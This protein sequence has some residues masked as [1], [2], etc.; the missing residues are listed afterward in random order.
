M[1]DGLGNRCRRKRSGIAR[2]MEPRTDARIPFHGVTR[3]RIQAK[4]ISTFK[5]GTRFQ[6]VRFPKATALSALLIYWVMGGSGRR[7]GSSHFPA[8]KG[9]RF[10]RATLPTFSM[11]NI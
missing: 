1:L 6:L 3:L 7:P 8:S 5:A 9:F 4:V 2:R 11:A 10:I